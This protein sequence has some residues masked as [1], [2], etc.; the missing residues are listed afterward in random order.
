MRKPILFCCVLIIFFTQPLGAETKTFVKEYTYQASELDS[1]YSSRTISLEI[2]KRQLLEELGTC[3]V[4]TTEVKDFRLSRDQITTYSAG[5]VGVELIEDRWD[6]RT[7]WIRARM[8]ADPK[9]VASALQKIIQDE[10]KTKELEETRR[11][12]AELTEEV[13][14][15]KRII[16]ELKQPTKKMEQEYLEKIKGLTGV[17]L[18]DKEIMAMIANDW[19]TVIQIASKRIELDPLYGYAYN[20]RAIAYLSSGKPQKAVEDFRKAIDLKLESA[21]DYCNL[22]VAYAALGDYQQAL[23]AYNK[24]LDLKPDYGTGYYNRGNLYKQI[25]NNQQAVRD[26]SRAIELKPDYAGAY[27]NR[28]ATHGAAGS[29]QQAIAD[30]SRVIELEPRNAEAWY[31]RGTGY[32]KMRKYLAAL[33]DFS[34]AIELKPD[35]SNAYYNRGITY[36]LIGNRPEGIKDLQTAA[37]LGNGNARE[38]LARLKLF[39]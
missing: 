26:Y 29:L 37:R 1:K 3:L 39:W 34:R 10:T 14:Q 13:A 20:N 32:G 18:A 6:G 7:Y 27:A 22:G 38:S 19:Q 24:A 21:S 12:S 23:A 28:G 30:F 11:K 16:A 31:N 4:S 25:G 33:D 5:V 17:E 8:T 9:E 2:I 35:Y 36:D 15:L